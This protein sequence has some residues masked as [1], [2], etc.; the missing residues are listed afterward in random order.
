MSRGSPS[1]Q[2]ARIDAEQSGWRRLLRPRSICADD[3][4][5]DLGKQGQSQ[6]DRDDGPELAQEFPRRSA[7]QI[8]DR[9]LH[10][11]KCGIDRFH[12]TLHA[13]VRF[14]RN[15]SRPMRYCVSKW[16][17]SIKSMPRPLPVVYRAIYPLSAGMSHAVTLR[18]LFF[19]RRST[20]EFICAPGH[21][22]R[23]RDRFL[24]YHRCLNS[25]C[26]AW[27]FVWACLPGLRPC[28]GFRTGCRYL[29]THSSYGIP[30][31]QWRT[32]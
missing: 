13:R 20:I 26:S 11:S 31:W 29:V 2:T 1:G 3:R 15:G 25:A 14:T 32:Q 9:R 8:P 21:F 18:R 17:F 12:A 7:R 22:R 10:C 5:Q 28:I 16:G 4:H 30:I 23:M 27:P 24:D 19:C 6:T